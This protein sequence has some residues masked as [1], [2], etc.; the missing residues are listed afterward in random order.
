MLGV[1]TFY[2][3][4]NV[5]GR[6]TVLIVRFSVTLDKSG[7]QFCVKRTS[8]RPYLGQY[9]EFSML[10]GFWGGEDHSDV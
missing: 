2:F 4:N 7:S 5:I 10:T 6:R 8:R 1:R 3:R 9:L